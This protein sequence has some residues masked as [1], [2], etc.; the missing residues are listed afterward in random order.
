MK[1]LLSLLLIAA[2]LVVVTPATM[3]L[4]AQDYDPV[5]DSFANVNA[6]YLTS[7]GGSST[8]DFFTIEDISANTIT[9]VNVWARN[10]GYCTQEMP[11]FQQIHEQYASQ[12]VL[13]VGVATTGQNSTYSQDYTYFVNNGY[14]YMHVKIDSAIATIANYNGYI[15]QT[16][17][18]DSNGTCIDFIGGAT[19]YNVL[20]NKVETYLAQYAPTYYNVTFKDGLTGST[21]STVSVKAGQAA[22]APTAPVH[23]GYE[24]VGWDKDFSNVQSNMTVTALYEASVSTLAGDVDCDGAITFSDI[25]ML[26]MNLA[27]TSPLSGQGLINADMDGDGTVGFSDVSAIYIFLIS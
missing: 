23:E 18:L 20:K 7:G 14:T 3:A 25:S 1:K 26:A 24:F 10:C 6:P 9:I 16:F 19:T 5:G 17:I 4:D 15:P 8:T 12:G 27:G 11:Y 22:V 21:I 2:M 13:V